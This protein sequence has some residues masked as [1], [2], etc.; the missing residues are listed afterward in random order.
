MNHRLIRSVY[1]CLAAAIVGAG[2]LPASAADATIKVAFWNIM[3]GKGVDALPGY[4]AP[5]HN[6]TNCTDPSQPLNAWGVGASQTAIQ[7]ALSDPSVVALGLAE[8]WTSV[9][10]SPDHVRQALNWKAASSEQN[11]VALVARYGFAGAEKWQQLDTSLNTSPAD[12]MWVLRVPVCLDAACSQSMPVYV[13]HWYGTGTNAQASYDKQAQQ[14]VAFLNAT[15]GGQPHVLVGDLNTWEGT[16]PVCSQSP[17]NT[18]LTYLRGAGYL[19][20]WTMIHGGA[21]GYTGMADRAGCGI[22]EGYTWKR[23][24]YAWTPPS[25]LPIDIQRWAM[26]PPGDAS[27]SDHY[28]IVVTLPYPGTPTTTTTTSTTTTTPPPPTTTTTSSTTTTTTTSTTTAMMPGPGANGDI[29]LYAKRATIVGSA[30][31]PVND[32]TAAGGVRISNPD[33]GAAKLAAPFASPA[34]YFEVPFKAE[35]GRAYRLWIRG[36]AQN[37]SWQNDS[38][39]VQFSGSVDASG[40]PLFRIGTTSATVVSIEEASGM[41]VSGW[42]WQDNG[43]GLNVLG[44]VVYFNSTDETLRIQVRE[45]GL[46][47]DQIVLS[48]VQYATTAPGAGKNDTTILSET[49]TS[50]TTSSP[51][52]TSTTTT[53]PATTTTTTST[54]STTSAGVVWTNAVNA[55]ATG[56]ALQ[57]TSGCGQCFDAGAVSTQ[58]VASGTGVS[59]SVAAAQRLFVGLGHDSS[60][61][62]SYVI[63]YAFSFW[64]SGAFEIRENNVYRTEGTYSASDTFRV[65]VNG[66]VVSYYKNGALIY[67]STV[68]VTAP[69]FADSSMNTIGAAISAAVVK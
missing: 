10:G 32:T 54:T 51:T 61:S 43:Y 35:T 44:P 19:D 13:G 22:P 46:S 15:S 7:Q 38:T 65:A 17:N 3:S 40:A 30:W 4:S 68:P 59:F 20:A 6:T 31:S 26:N 18:S 27:P 2:A 14:T 55:V 9:C 34:S 1:V 66:T 69:L 52:T 29:V 53:S 45:D 64:Q 57:K 56:S 25:Y 42:G 12:T 62:T 39:F 60:A 67:T 47:I 24:D 11:G 23:I 41:G 33:A 36:K 5:F 48:P 37:D 50:V 63:D 28:G 16:A 21:E 8:S 58:T 49:F